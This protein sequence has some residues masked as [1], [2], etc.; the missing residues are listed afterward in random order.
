MELVDYIKK[1]D[2]IGEKEYKNM[3]SIYGEDTVRIV[4]NNIINSINVSNE[5][6][7]N[8]FA[9]YINLSVSKDND[10]LKLLS[11]EFNSSDEDEIEID[12]VEYYSENYDRGKS[13]SIDSVELY[14]KEIGNWE[15]MTEE[16]E[17]KYGEII[18]NGR[19]TED[20]NSLYLLKT[21]RD[22]KFF[23]KYEQRV[24]DFNTVLRVV[25]EADTKDRRL[26]LLKYINRVIEAFGSQ[27]SL[28]KYEKE[29]YNR[30]EACIKKNESL[31]SLDGFHMEKGK[32]ISCEELKKQID[33]IKD[34]RY[35]LRKY[36]EANLRLVVAIAKKYNIVGV[37]ME[38]LIQEGNIGLMKATERYDVTKGFKFS[39]YATWWIRQCITRYIADNSRTIRLPVHID[40]KV[41]KYNLT[42]NLLNNQLGREPSKQEI[43]NA[44]NISLEKLEEI[45][46]INDTITIVSLDTPV[47]GTED[48]NSNIGDFIE[49]KEKNVEA[50]CI[51][52]DLSL[53]TKKALSTLSER[54]AEIL[55]LRFGLNDGKTRTLEEIANEF[56]VTRERIRQIE[57][58]ALRKLRAPSRKKIFDGYY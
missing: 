27:G 9:W 14:L 8:K 44:M 1:I 40:E 43:A 54:E 29:K 12:R 20:S 26:E 10:D 41:K 47:K 49:S 22:E 37:K 42:K 30:I 3:I 56:N 39:T 23:G 13:K 46:I 52:N 32:N 50:Q 16:E 2:I 38:D 34:Y 55:R 33:L 6:L 4:L 25:Y 18:Y 57:D 7:Y 45:I 15:L 21:I 5:K 31:K 48:Q 51:A 58:K 28:Y 36:N 53:Q 35:A 24:I 19:K 11:E 17:R